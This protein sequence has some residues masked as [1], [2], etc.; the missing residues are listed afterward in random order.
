MDQVEA[1]FEEDAENIWLP[2]DAD[3]TGRLPRHVVAD[4]KFE[5][6][7]AGPDDPRLGVGYSSLGAPGKIV[8][9]RRY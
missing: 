5:L 6:L 7:F 4:P 2:A 9:W 1:G 8:I 3:P